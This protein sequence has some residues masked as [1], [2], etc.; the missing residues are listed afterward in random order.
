[1]MKRTSIFRNLPLFVIPV[2]I[3]F[4][5]TSDTL[6]QGQQITN[7]LS[8][9]DAINIAREQSPDALTAKQ[10]FRAS[11]WQYRS[12][13]AAYLP[14]LVLTG[15]L[16]NFN[17]SIEQVSLAEGEALLDRQYIDWS[18]NAS[19]RQRIGPTGG[20]IFIQSGLRR[21][22]NFLTEPDTT[23]TQHLSTPIN[24]GYSQPIFQFNSYKWE[25]RIEPMRYEEA[26][27]AYLEDM[28][29]VSIT[30]T[31]FF[32]NLLLAQISVKIAEIN[33][34]NYDTLY[35][36]AQGRYNL[37][38]IAE[39]DLLQ[40]E[41][42]F[43]R[44]SAAVENA[45]LDEENRMFRL[46]SYLR[47]KDDIPL[48]LIPPSGIEPFI[49]PFDKALTEARAN[50]SDALAFNRREI[51]AERDLNQ[52]KMDGRFDAEL[53]A[54]FGLTQSSV[55][56][57]EVYNN[58]LDQQQLRVGLTLPILDWGVARGRI[59]IAES[60]QE[61]V[62]TAIEQEQ[63]DFDQ[64]VFLLVAQFN[65]QYDQV[66]IAAKTDTVAQKGYAITKAR[67]LIGKI[68]ITDLNIAQAES[69]QSK[70]NYINALW[71]YWRNYYNLRRL[72][73]YDFEYNMPI[74]VDHRELL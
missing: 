46:K 65:M 64:E 29:N 21:L 59:K 15:T 35:K 6:S 53:F 67:Y 1:M 56:L 47:I 3:F 26:K 37:G 10:Q 70:S 40:L 58:P 52:A 44:A 62:R 13:K 30:A 27:K 73:L 61:I 2:V 50:R 11:Y 38:K 60:N 71:T 23:I 4:S 33:L 41:L 43:L 72:T 12:F 14:S 66:V 31:N 25:R 9:L 74:V 54:V 69:D 28:E 48:E 36:I 5:T 8:L 49:V 18:V 45:R 19:I 20:D 57:D 16:P 42:Q 63:I 39:N 55:D 51:E 22:D 68:S 17:R 34:A 24:I 7:K 32:F